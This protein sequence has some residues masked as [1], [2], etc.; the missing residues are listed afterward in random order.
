MHASCLQREACDAVVALLDGL[1]LLLHA[2]GSLLRA[3][4][5]YLPTA[6]RELGDAYVK[7]E[8]RLHRG[9]SPDFMQQFE[10]QWRDYLTH[11]RRA[12]GAVQ[13]DAHAGGASAVGREMTAEEVGALSDEQ[14]V[15]SAT[16]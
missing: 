6:A 9:A 2:A 15:C 14:K 16:V 12:G 4:Q 10:R 5:N 1:H 7:K 11:L 13:H 8:F 3:H